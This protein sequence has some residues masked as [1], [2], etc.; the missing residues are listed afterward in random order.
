[1]HEALVGHAQ[2]PQVFLSRAQFEARIGL[3]PGGLSGA[4]LPPPDAIIGPVNNDGSLPRGTTRGWLPETIDH[5]KRT[6]LGQGFRTDVRPSPRGWRTTP[7]RSSTT[8]RFLA[9]NDESSRQP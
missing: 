4:K 1:M 9:R 2:P 6:R 7:A 3:R 8:G 5:W